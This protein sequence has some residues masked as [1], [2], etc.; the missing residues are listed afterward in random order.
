M[1]DVPD[2]DEFEL[3][4]FGGGYGESICAHVGS[5]IW[6]VVDS[7]L[8]PESGNPVALDYLG[9]LGVEIDKLVGLVLVTHW[10]DDHIRGISKI[11]EVCS[12]S[13]VAVSGA[14]RSK[15]AIA[16]ILSQESAST[17]SG[18]GVDELRKILETCRKTGRL[19]FAKTN[20]P[21]FPI[22]PGS[23]P[24]VTALSPSEDSCTRSIEWLIGAAF[25]AD[26]TVARRYKA[27][28]TPNGASVAS[29]VKALGSQ[30]LLGADLEVSTNP[31]AGW[32]AVVDYA[33]PSDQSIAIKIPH[34][35]SVTGHDDL[36]WTE[37][38]APDSLAIVTPWNRGRGH[39]P[40]EEDLDRIRSVAK[41]VYITAM[42]RLRRVHK[43]AEVDRLINRLHGRDLH[44]LRGWG[45]V[46]ARRKYGEDGWRVEKFGD[47]ELVSV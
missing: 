17:A 41:D 22:P 10:D 4:V 11:V 31:L 6:I 1:T 44:E 16:F 19:T 18:S 15:E 20:L 36:I 8:H 5:G 13:R 39:L 33:K 9:E 45:H 40:G 25:S 46:R 28:D 32:K 14:L 43:T 37:L 38:M 47:A 21:L 7:C 26:I 30:V 23:D 35:G 42:P 2:S 29:Y 24:N 34:H 27:P 12:S 3:S